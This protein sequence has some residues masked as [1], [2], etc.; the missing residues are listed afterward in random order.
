MN[1]EFLAGD[2]YWRVFGPETE[3]SDSTPLVIFHGLFGSGDNWRSQALAL[4]ENRVVLVAD[5]PDH[6]RSVHCEEFSYPFIATLLWSA[7]DAALE[8]LEMPSLPL[9]LLGHSMGGK[10]AMAMAV[11]QPER[12]AQL[13]VAD[14][15][16][17]S[18]PPRHDE[19]FAAL[20]AVAKNPVTSRS[21]A[22]AIMAEF[23]PQK[24]IRMFLLKSLIPTPV[25][26]DGGSVPETYAWR[27]NLPGLRSGYDA[28][29]DRPFVATEV[30]YL[31]PTLFV[32]GGASP[33]VSEEDHATIAHHFP[34]SSIHV[35][36]GVGHWLHAE[37][38]DEF[39]SVVGAFVS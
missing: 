26:G 8:E 3:V 9:V 34:D 14:I 5:L 21:G 38:R 24:A 30:R 35:I 22:D 4:A 18:Y 31:G 15:A 33:Y 1:R 32:V 10:A 29:R 2:I 37:A 25:R 7:I 12:T 39:I 17:R 23:I 20:D 11:S 16:P 28:I 36:E 13:I 19:I 27:L 6:G